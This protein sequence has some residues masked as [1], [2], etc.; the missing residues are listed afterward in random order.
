MYRVWRE[1]DK[2][3]DVWIWGVYMLNNII[4]LML[5]IAGTSI[6]LGIAAYLFVQA[7][8]EFKQ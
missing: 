8:N 4:A 6:G 7:Y 3:L 5:A 2:G 1:W